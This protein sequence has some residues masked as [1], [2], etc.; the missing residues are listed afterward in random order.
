M[1]QPHV[2][3]FMCDQ[4]QYQRQGKIDPVAHT[5]NLDR[6]ADDGTFFTH[7]HSANGQ[8]VP[9][10]ASMQTGLY[11]HE[12][13]V[14]IIYGFHNHTAHLTGKQ[15]TVGHVFQDAGYTTAY[16][17]KTHFGTP[18]RELGYDVGAGGR[19]TRRPLST[20]DQEIVGTA[21]D[22]LEDYDAQKPLFLTVSV[23]MPHPPFE[24]V[25]GFADQYALEDMVIPRSFYEDDLSDKPQF[26]QDHMNDGNHGIF[27]EG[28]LREEMRQYY[29]MIS[30]VDRLFGE[31]RRVFEE[32]GMW[33]NT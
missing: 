32:K 16:F 24:V 13:E 8:C 21:L 6:L 33:D 11:P 23:N 22:F 19:K 27:D 1:E 7:F 4:M 5:P 25:E 12:A 3:F 15:K 9:S 28:E 30:E 20:G 29:T 18:L 26:L 31:V 10:R 17:G 14:M 2:L